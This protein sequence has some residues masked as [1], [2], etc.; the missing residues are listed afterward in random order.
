MLS[1]TQGRRHNAE[2]GAPIPTPF[3]KFSYNGIC[4]RRGGLSLVAA[5]PGG[6]KSALVQNIVQRGDD[7]GGVASTLYFSADSD[8]NTMF[9][10][11]AAIATGYTLQEV[12]RLLEEGGHLMLEERVRAASAHVRYCFE[13]SLSIDRIM[14]EID[15]YALVF[16]RYPEVVVLDNLSNVDAGFED[17]FRNLGESSFD[18]LNIAR[19][20]DAAVIALHHVGGEHENGDKPIPLSGLRG[21]VSKLPALVLTLHRA[22]GLKVSVVKNRSGKGDPTGGYGVTLHAD[23]SRMQISD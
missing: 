11:S 20:T 23:L 1:L 12:E 10:R 7:E 9:Q 16:G 2:Q 8:A 22:E 5:A 4:F 3:G 19:D 15:A 21:K 14:D 13:S 17:E 6:G 18:L